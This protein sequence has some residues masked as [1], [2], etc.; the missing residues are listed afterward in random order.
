MQVILIILYIMTFGV[1]CYLMWGTLGIV[2]LVSPLGMSIGLW[3]N[4]LALPKRETPAYLYREFTQDLFRASSS[5][6]KTLCKLLTLIGVGTAMIGISPLVAFVQLD[7]T[8]GGIA[9]C[10]LLLPSITNYLSWTIL[11]VCYN[12]VYLMSA[13]LIVPVATMILP[14]TAVCGQ[15]FLI[16]PYTFPACA[17]SANWWWMLLHLVHIYSLLVVMAERSFWKA[18]LLHTLPSRRDIWAR[19]MH[20]DFN[21]LLPFVLNRRPRL[22]LPGGIAPV[23]PSP[24]SSRQPVPKGA[25][26]VEKLVFVNV[27]LYQ[28]PPF[29]YSFF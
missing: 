3:T 23:T 10:I 21:W 25:H 17:T 1:W 27:P 7:V 16:D 14:F 20:A 19:P 22:E 12:Y 5:V 9:L 11:A 28:V 4:F 8:G 18:F 24:S 2:E 29:C 6:F 13:L 26:K 15:P